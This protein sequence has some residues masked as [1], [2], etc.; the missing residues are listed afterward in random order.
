MCY[1]YPH[2]S[3][4][5]T[6]GRGKH[7]LYQNVARMSSSGGDRF[8]AAHFRPSGSTPSLPNCGYVRVCKGVCGCVRVCEGVCGCVRVG[9]GGTVRGT[10]TYTH[11]HTIINVHTQNLL[12]AGGS[13]L[14]EKEKTIP[15][16]LTNI[17]VRCTRAGSACPGLR[18]PGH[19]RVL[20]AC[21]RAPVSL[22]VY[23][24]VQTCVCDWVAV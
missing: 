15:V 18:R 14:Q 3:E 12:C 16:V 8:A 23:L 24:C 21:L 7:A 19:P 2:H 1:W 5:R 10:H 13:L 4:P 6:S 17:P 20:R 9:V 22:C 11:T